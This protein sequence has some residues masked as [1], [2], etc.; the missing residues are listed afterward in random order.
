MASLI[1]HNP[2]EG[3]L[4]HIYKAEDE[5][6]KAGITFDV[7]KSLDEGRILSRDWELDW[8]LVGAELKI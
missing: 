1:V 8:S 4:K 3:Q 6:S 7:G 2:T 5:L